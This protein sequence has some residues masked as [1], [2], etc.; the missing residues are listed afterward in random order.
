MLVKVRALE[1]RLKGEYYKKLC[2]YHH[3][4]AMKLL[5]DGNYEESEYHMEL[6][7]AYLHRH[8]DTA[9]KYVETVL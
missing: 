9:I 5:D 4:K 6:S 8:C 1:L 3:E 7:I 2:D